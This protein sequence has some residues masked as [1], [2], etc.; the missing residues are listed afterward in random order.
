MGRLARAKQPSMAIQIIVEFDRADDARVDDR[1]RGTVPA[2][3]GV[4]NGEENYFVVLSYDYEC[5]FCFKAQFFTGA[6]DG[7][8]DH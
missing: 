8:G 4:G 7:I 6:F 3:V 2:P 5:N 1:A